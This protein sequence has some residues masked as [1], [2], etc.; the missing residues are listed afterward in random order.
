MSDETTTIRDN[1]KFAASEVDRILK[2]QPPGMWH[3]MRVGSYFLILPKDAYRE[4]SRDRHLWQEKMLKSAGQ[5]KLS[6]CVCGQK[7]TL[8][9]LCMGKRVSPWWAHILWFLFPYGIPRA[10]CNRPHCVFWAAAHEAEFVRFAGQQD[11]SFILG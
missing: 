8:E 9:N 6:C 10:Y 7:L 3:V 5:G 1:R 2:K 4:E 11:V